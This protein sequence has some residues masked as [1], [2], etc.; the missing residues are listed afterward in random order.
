MLFCSDEL[1][2]FGWSIIANFNI[3]FSFR[4]QTL[5]LQAKLSEQ[6]EL[7]FTLRDENKNCAIKLQEEKVGTQIMDLL[8]QQMSI[9]VV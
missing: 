4:E 9:W 2:G 5:S 3:Y 8:K 6:T 1:F 7:I